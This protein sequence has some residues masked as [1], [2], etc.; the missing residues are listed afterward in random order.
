MVAGGMTMGVDETGTGTMV[1]PCVV[2]ACSSYSS[3]LL[4]F[5]VLEGLFVM[6]LWW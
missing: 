4:L 3:M 1:L 5:L 2:M 6:C